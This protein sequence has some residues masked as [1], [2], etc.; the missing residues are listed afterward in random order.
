MQTRATCANALKASWASTAGRVRVGRAARGGGGVLWGVHVD[1]HGGHLGVGRGAARPVLWDSGQ[2]GAPILRP[3]SPL[4]VAGTPSGC[5][6]RN[7]GRCLGANSTLCQ[8]PPGF[9]GLLCEFGKCPGLGQGLP[10]CPAVRIPETTA[11]PG[12]GGHPRL[13]P[14]GLTWPLG[15]PLTCRGHGHALQHEHAV[16]RRRLLHGVRREL[17]VCLPHRPQRQ[18]L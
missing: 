4:S 13:V 5:E 15:L 1:T 3:L 10:S 11:S 17:P 9:F 7:G 6:C 16:P 2:E 12:C 14:L 18:P 8:C